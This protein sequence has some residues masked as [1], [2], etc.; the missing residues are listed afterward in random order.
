M[1]IDS[2]DG[3]P[4]QV[5]RKALVAARNLR[6][7]GSLTLIATASEPFGGETTVIAL[8]ATLTSTGQRADPRPRQQRHAQ[9]RAAGRR[10]RRAGDHAGARRRADATLAGAR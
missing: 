3:V 5:A 6:D 1:L 8:D 9:A 10:G 2:L 7:G 4:P